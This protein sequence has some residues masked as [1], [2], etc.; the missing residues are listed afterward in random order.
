MSDRL[1]GAL[2]RA[3]ASGARARTARRARRLTGAAQGRR[4]ARR[5]APLGCVLRRSADTPGKLA[6]FAFAFEHLETAGYEELKLVAHRAGAQPTVAV[7]DRI[8]AQE[9]TAATKIAAQ[10]DRAVD[11][12]LREVGVAA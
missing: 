6:A 10:W 4:H 5:G 3:V 1:Q 12:S 7:V 2:Q 11:A 9:R 8:L